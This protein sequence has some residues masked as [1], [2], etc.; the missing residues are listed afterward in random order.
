MERACQSDYRVRQ[1]ATSCRDVE[2]KN[3]FTTEKKYKDWDDI[4]YE[5]VC[6]LIV[7]EGLSADDVVEDMM[8][9]L[10]KIGLF[11]HGDKYKTAKAGNTIIIGKS[12]GYIN[13]EI[14]GKVN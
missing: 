9:A 10:C 5:T 11:T 6:M 1:E 3:P 12:Q 2:M 4:H 7:D 14:E 8:P 13:L